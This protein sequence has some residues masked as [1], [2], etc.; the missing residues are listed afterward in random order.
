MS[1]HIETMTR[2]AR[3]PVIDILNH[4]IRNSFAAYPEEEVPY[5]AF[6]M[7]EKMRGGHPGVVAKEERGE[8]VAFGFLRP[9]SPFPTF[10]ATA[11]ISYFVRDGHTNQGI[12]GRMLEALVRQGKDKGITTILA[13]ISSLNDGSIRFHK[14]NGFVECGRFKQVG[15]KKGQ[16]FDVVW[17]QKMI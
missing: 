10:A 2:E 7:L 5:A 6:E 9:H 14:R 16:T 17:M 4:Y 1:V 15:R 13:S 11:E 3:E 12:G 8:V